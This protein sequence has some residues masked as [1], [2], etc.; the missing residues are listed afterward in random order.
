M[1]SDLARYIHVST[2]AAWLIDALR[3]ITKAVPKVPQKYTW[4]Q[5]GPCRTFDWN[6][7]I[8]ISYSTSETR[9]TILITS[10]FYDHFQQLAPKVTSLYSAYNRSQVH[11]QAATYSLYI[12]IQSNAL[13]RE[14]N[15][16]PIVFW[17]H[18]CISII[19]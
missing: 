13:R 16:L 4:I 2:P 15:W 14:K 1:Q 7:L 11:V 17:M 10:K 18:K 12:W 5:S 3:T 9:I 19:K 6:H 8:I